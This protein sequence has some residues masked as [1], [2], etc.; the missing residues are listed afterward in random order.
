[1][2]AAHKFGNLCHG[3]VFFGD[4]DFPVTEFPN[5]HDVTTPFC[6]AASRIYISVAALVIKA[7]PPAMVMQKHFQFPGENPSYP[8]RS[9]LTFGCPGQ[10][11]TSSKIKLNLIQQK[12][13]GG[14][15]EFYQK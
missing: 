4:N 11:K 2:M 7:A 12:S 8:G 1:M 13:S 5:S 3:R 9:P 14:N 10:N 6:L 15:R